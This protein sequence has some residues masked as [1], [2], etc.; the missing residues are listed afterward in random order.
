MKRLLGVAALLGLAATGTF[1][2]S[3]F[4][5][6]G[7]L[8]SGVLIDFDN[9]YTY[10]TNYTAA[11]FSSNPGSQMTTIGK[12]V[13]WCAPFSDLQTKKNA[14]THEYTFIITGTSLGTV[15]S[16]DA[17]G[18]YYDTDYTN[19]SFVI[20]EDSSPDAPNTPPA[21]PNANVPALWVDGT[22][23]LTGQYLTF[24]TNITRDAFTG[25]Y[26]S[27]VRADYQFTGGT[28]FSRV[29]SGQSLFQGTWCPGG[30]GS[31]KCTVPVGFTN[32]PNDK[33]DSPATTGAVPSTWGTIKQLYR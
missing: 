26:S 20:Y 9:G 32:K 7:S 29:G 22:P 28:L 11:T 21:I 4:A 31:G 23:I 10:E 18:T 2:T 17:G 27:S 13:L 6:C 3:A 24:H 33:W 19:A 5:Q 25:F 12:I 14:G 30:S 15:P 16:S 1:A 8:G